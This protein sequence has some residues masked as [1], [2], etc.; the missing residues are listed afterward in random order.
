MYLDGNDVRALSGKRL[1]YR[2]VEET[3]AGAGQR[4]SEIT[5]GVAG[6]A[7]VDTIVTAGFRAAIAALKAL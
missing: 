6:E 2:A 3:S 1:Q 5:G 4:T 7:I